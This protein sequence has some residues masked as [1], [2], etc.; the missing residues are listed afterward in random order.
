MG[1]QMCQIMEVVGQQVLDIKFILEINLGYFIMEWFN[2]E[3]Q[4][5]CF[6]DLVMIVFDQV[7]LF[8][9][10]IL[11]DFFFYVK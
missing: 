7:V 5:D 9:G 2:V 3:V 4:E 10:V 11:E 6:E 8:E 1:V